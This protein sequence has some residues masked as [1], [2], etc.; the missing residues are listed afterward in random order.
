MIGDAAQHIGGPGLGIDAV[1]FCRADQGVDRGSA[2]TASVGPANNHAR[3]TNTGFFR[4]C[5]GAVTVLDLPGAMITFRNGIN[6]L[7]QIVGSYLLPLPN[8][9]EAQIACRAR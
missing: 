2:L 4:D 9:D 5:N 8:N 1:E 3:R 6:D 7:G